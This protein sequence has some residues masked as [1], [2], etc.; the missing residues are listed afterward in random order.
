MFVRVPSE[1]RT[2]AS[3]DLLSLVN[4]VYA[5]TMS[6]GELLTRYISRLLPCQEVCRAEAG[7]MAASVE[8][9]VRAHC[10]ARGTPPATFA[11][12]FKQ[13]HNGNL[14]RDAVIAALAQAVSRV[15]PKAK[16]DLD[17]PELC[18]AVQVV[19]AMCCV[20][21]VDRWKAFHKY[22]VRGLREHLA[23]AAEAAPAS[24]AAVA[25]QAAAPGAAAGAAPL[26]HP[27]ERAVSSA[28][29]GA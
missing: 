15:V 17:D 27:D 1:M 25:A 3:P 19:R 20:C 22:S 16:V 9:A 13:R 29:A 10:A 14:D 12:H 21:V 8:E 23:A 2:A 7:R 28:P 4:S 26:S 11:I 6:G 24:A 18:V 5:S